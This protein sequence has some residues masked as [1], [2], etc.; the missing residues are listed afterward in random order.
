MGKSLHQSI[1]RVRA[2]LLALA[3][4]ALGSGAVVAEPVFPGVQFGTGVGE[5]T[6]RS[7]G[8]TSRR[9]WKCSGR[10]GLESAIIGACDGRA[11]SPGISYKPAYNR[12]TGRN[13]ARGRWETTSRSCRLALR[14][15]WE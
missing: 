7:S 8:S 15:W 10:A 9:W 1:G 14:G 6:I 2:H 13:P 11:A 4:L 5:S 12:G 3:G